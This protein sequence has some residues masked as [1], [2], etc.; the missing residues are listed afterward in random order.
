[1]TR[2]FP[3]QVAVLLVLILIPAAASAQQGSVW[4][5]HRSMALDLST[6]GI[7]G[8]MKDNYE[9][10]P[11]KETWSRHLVFGPNDSV[12]L[13]ANSQNYEPGE[14][15][16]D[17][18]ELGWEFVDTTYVNLNNGTFV[19]SRKLVETKYLVKGERPKISWQLTNEE[20][21]YLGFRVMKA[22]ATIDST[23]VEAWFTPDIPTSTGPGLYG[24]LPGLILMLSNP[25]V[26]EVYAAESIELEPIS[27]DL[28]PPV[29]GREIS[30]KKYE[31]RIKWEIAE[32]Q[33]QFDEVR[34]I[35]EQAN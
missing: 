12:M 32:N 2:Y 34:K 33:R 18:L 9:P 35:I 15:D 24:G 7:S 21:S 1:M 25:S 22:Q 8:L 23:I 10:T 19:E 31:D 11:N 29:I 30:P 20:Q 14:R 4:Y 3:S 27:F 26:G 5:S 13:L 16:E 6:D 28:A 17:G